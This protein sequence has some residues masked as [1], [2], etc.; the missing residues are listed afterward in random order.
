MKDNCVI[1]YKVIDNQFGNI[2]QD[3]SKDQEVI[4]GMEDVHKEED[5]LEGL[6]D[7]ILKE[8]KDDVHWNEC[9]GNAN[10]NLISVTN[11]E[12]L[13]RSAIKKCVKYG[14]SE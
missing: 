7:D 13:I 5:K 6:Q 1:C 8:L 12:I 14:G 11:V 9:E 3:C 4:A 10:Y 2:C